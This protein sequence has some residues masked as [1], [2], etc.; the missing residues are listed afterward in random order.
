LF[1]PQGFQG[2]SAGAGAYLT[3]FCN[4]PQERLAS[5]RHQPASIG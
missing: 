5:G 4:N 1:N 2:V 3:Y